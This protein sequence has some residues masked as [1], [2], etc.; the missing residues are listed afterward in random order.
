M[1]YFIYSEDNIKRLVYNMKDNKEAIFVLM[2]SVIAILVLVVIAVM[3]DNLI[4]YSGALLA[5]F[6]VFRGIRKL[7]QE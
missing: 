1:I 6:L 2:I 3:Y 7:T 4:V 5:S